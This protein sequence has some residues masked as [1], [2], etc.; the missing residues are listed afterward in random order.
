M[1]TSQVRDSS[2]R[3]SHWSPGLTA[4]GFCPKIYPEQCLCSHVE[5]ASEGLMNILLTSPRPVAKISSHL[6]ILLLRPKFVVNRGSRSPKGPF[7]QERKY[8]IPTCVTD[9]ER[10]TEQHQ[11]GLLK[12]SAHTITTAHRLLAPGRHPPFISTRKKECIS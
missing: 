8:Q 11:K 10:K 5:G 2:E 3:R 4:Q 6:K 7:L 9:V 1:L 12:G